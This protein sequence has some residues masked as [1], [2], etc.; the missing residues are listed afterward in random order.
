MIT[1]NF[2]RR[3]VLFTSI[4]LVVILVTM[5]HIIPS[6]AQVTNTE[7]GGPTVPVFTSTQSQYCTGGTC[8]TGGSPPLP[9]NYTKSVSHLPVM[10]IHLSQT[11]EILDRYNMTGCITVKDLIPYDNSNQ[12]LSGKFVNHDGIYT[13]TPP[14]IK[15]NWLAYAYSDHIITC[16]ECYFDVTATEKSKEIIEQ[17]NT[18]TY[19][20]KTESESKNVLY[21]FANRYMQGCDTA[22]IGNIPGLLNDTIHFMLNNCIS[23]ATNFNGTQK[24]TRVLHPFSF[25]NPF[26]SLKEITLLK[27]LMHGKSSSNT[28]MT[29]GGY[30]PSDCI[31]HKCDFIDPYKKAGY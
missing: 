27:N 9:T 23:T 31:R 11:C 1:S 19:V 17:T 5:P 24:H 6:Y 28:N 7:V 30:G 26:S 13:R 10:L 22:T 20:N 4:L 15:N 3:G 25:D 21:N 14:Q 29:S 2:V 16:V 18:F 12:M 8:N